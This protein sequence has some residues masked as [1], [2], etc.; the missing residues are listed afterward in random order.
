LIG[1]PKFRPGIFPRSTEKFQDL[2]ST[3]KTILVA[4][5]TESL[6]T[7][8]DFFM[9]ERGLNRVHSKTLKETLLTL[10]GQRVDVLVLDADL[11]GEDCG[12]ISII[13]GIEENLPIIV[14]A[15]TNTPEFESKIRQHRIFFY[16]IKSFG[17]QDLETA[18][19]NALNRQQN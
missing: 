2:M 6:V 8:L 14:C 13:K 5:P 18:I 19:S 4:E 1:W 10:Q 7:E 15:E 16:H 3:A 17:I 12:F 11:L 9:T